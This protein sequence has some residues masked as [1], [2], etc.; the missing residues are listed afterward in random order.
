MAVEVIAHEL[1]FWDNTRRRPGDRFLVPDEFADRAKWWHRADAPPPVEVT[2]DRGPTPP[3]NANAQHVPGSPADQ[4]RKGAKSSA[5][6][7]IDQL[8]DDKEP[9]AEGDEGTAA[10]KGARGKRGAD[11]K[12]I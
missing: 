5:A 10:P 1:G 3:G 9:F 7:V 11:Q 2:G 8:L 4:K 6:R 12:V